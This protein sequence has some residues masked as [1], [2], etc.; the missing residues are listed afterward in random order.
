M[1]Q[2]IKGDYLFFTIGNLIADASIASFAYLIF[3]IGDL[4]NRIHHYIFILESNGLE[5]IE[6]Q[7]IKTAFLLDN[8]IYL[9]ESNLDETNKEDLIDL[10]NKKHKFND[11]LHFL[12]L[13]F[14][15]GVCLQ[16]ISL[17]ITRLPHPP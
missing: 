3:K 4:D 7:K 10:Y 13:M 9:N 6:E 15:L 14:A 5:K 1:E 16:L 12:F 8:I 11:Y 17:T 2:L